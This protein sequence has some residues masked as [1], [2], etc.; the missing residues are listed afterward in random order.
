MLC[1]CGREPMA[2]PR[3]GWPAVMIAEGW[4]DRDFIRD[5]S[6]RPVPGA[7]RHGPL[8]HRRPT[9]PRRRSHGHYVAW[10]RR[11]WPAR[12]RTIRRP[13]RLRSSRSGDPHA[14]RVRDVRDAAPAPSTC[15]ARVRALRRA[16]PRVPARARRADH[17]RARRR[18]SS[19]PRGCSG[20][21]ARCPTSTGRGSSSTPTRRQTV[22]AISLLYALT[23]CFDAPGGNVRP[24]RPAVNDLAPLALLSE[25]GSATKALG[26]AERPLGPGRHGWATA[27]DVYRAILHGTPYPV[28]GHGRLR[29]QHCCSPSRTPSWRARGA[30]EASTSSSTPISS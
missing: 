4:Y 6:Q 27:R 28:R 1:A 8:P 15:R 3:S 11:R 17:R 25:S 19:R 13:R 23:G 9:S 16:L 29:R 5:W 26:L 24:S 22:R 7:R 12:W 20:S 30:R 2:H 18:R 10:D 14:R 21:G